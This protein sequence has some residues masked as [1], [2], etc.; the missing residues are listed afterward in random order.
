MQL[1]LIA[2]DLKDAVSAVKAATTHGTLPVTE[3]VRIR[4]TEDGRV[5]FACTNLDETLARTVDADVEEGG[6]VCVPAD[7]FY[8]LARRSRASWAVKLT[9]EANMLHYQAGPLNATI[10]GLPAD[11]FPDLGSDPET[12][13]EVD[14]E[15]FH[16]AFGRVSGHV[17]TEKSRPKLQSVHLDVSEADATYLIATNGHRFGRVEVSDLIEWV[18]ED[19]DSDVLVPP[20]AFER[21]MKVALGLG[22]ERANVGWEGGW[23]ELR[24]DGVRALSRMVNGP[25]LNYRQVIPK[26][27]DKEMIALRED[28]L[29]VLQ[30]V[31]VLASN[32]TYR[33]AL[34][35]EGDQ[36]TVQV[37]TADR[38]TAEEPVTTVT[39]DDEDGFRLGFNW[40]YLEMVLQDLT[41]ERVRWTFKAPER[42]VTIEPYEADD[43]PEAFYL[44][45]PLRLLD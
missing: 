9:T 28:L 15:A 12:R 10:N 41:C 22:V 23:I 4:A 6:G 11:E 24:A 2:G 42:A 8:G 45:M 38:G 18:G 14:L 19:T 20:A 34:E 31:G 35:L 7:D 5:E 26:D 43:H 21:A 13:L 44:C 40:K 17:S 36:L 25:Y 29:E 37:Q 3:S 32:Q 39:W 16:D 1:T 30:R 33:T 27:N